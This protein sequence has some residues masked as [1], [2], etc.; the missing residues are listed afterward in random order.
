MTTLILVSDSHLIVVSTIF[1]IVL[2][3]NIMKL[4][5]NL[6]FVLKSAIFCCV[7]ETRR[8]DQ[9]TTSNFSWDFLFN[10]IDPQEEVQQLLNI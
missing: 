8:E 7:L 10:T 9:P 5:C 1:F 4:V 3:A 2:P 6:A